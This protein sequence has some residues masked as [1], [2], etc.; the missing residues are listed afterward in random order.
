VDGVC[1]DTACEGTCFSCVNRGQEGTCALASDNSDVRS[2]CGTGCSACF[3][4]YCLPA[5]PGTNPHNTCDNGLACD[6]AGGCGV[7][8]GA[9]CT[10]ASACSAG[11]CLAG[12]CRVHAEGNVYS[13]VL[14]GN[15][16]DRYVMAVTLDAAGRAVALVR[17]LTYRSAVGSSDVTVRDM[18]LRRN[19]LGGWDGVTLADNPACNTNFTPYLSQSLVAVGTQLLAVTEYDPVICPHTPGQIVAQWITPNLS[20]GRRQVLELGAIGDGVGVRNLASSF[21]GHQVTVA[22][23]FYGP[24]DVVDLRL[25]R[26]NM[27]PAAG[28]Q[29]WEYSTGM[30][31]DARAT[32]ALVQANHATYAVFGARPTGTITV[33]EVV[34]ME[35]HGTTGVEVARANTPA[36]C[37]PA[38]L[39][40][41]P[42]D[43]PNPWVAMAGEATGAFTNAVMWAEF[44]PEA[45]EGQRLTSVQCVA[46]AAG[47]LVT[48]VYPA[49]VALGARAGVVYANLG[50]HRLHLA[51][52]EAQAAWSELALGAAFE[53][54]T[55]I[56]SLVSD[57]AAGTGVYAL[58]V[59]DDGRQVPLAPRVGII[60]P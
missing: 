34:V 9:A 4:G 20:L 35:I 10:T 22:A 50:D 59:F 29:G 28:S 1:C 15:P 47:G 49:P 5:Q 2:Q 55:S 19:E 48:G 45:P 41:V 44:H 33:G 54:S 52:R 17:D 6:N 3:G 56:A 37:E 30:V 60:Q 14:D 31:A 46:T 23:S 12:T 11:A 16:A 40:A 32:T 27:A 39:R 26:W 42:V 21:D 7:A 18:V 57:S 51:W 13:A 38:V 8:R 58:Q 25:A 24:S 53:S 43:G 36:E